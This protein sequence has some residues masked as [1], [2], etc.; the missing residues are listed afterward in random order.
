MCDRVRKPMPQRAP[1]RNRPSAIISPSI[2][3]ADFAHLARDCNDVLAHGAD[4]LHV[5]IMDGHFVP[6]LTIGHPVVKA[7]R[8]HTTAFLDCHLMVSDPAKWVD[9]FAKA[10]ADMFTF[11]IEA[12]DRDESLAEGAADPRVLALLARTRELGMRTGI[13]LC[14][15]TPWGA[16]LPYAAEIDMALVMTVRPGFGGQKFMPETMEKVRALRELYP[17]LNIEVDG[18]LST[19]TIEAAAE[20]GANVIVSGSGVFC[21]EKPAV[22]ISDMRAAIEAASR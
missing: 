7:I 22:A 17:D 12:F 3:S 18:G 1:D 8:K 9:E 15:E 6:N 13:A 14:P 2:L 4:W 19:A 20:A 5:D 11:H 10:G 21:V 16:L